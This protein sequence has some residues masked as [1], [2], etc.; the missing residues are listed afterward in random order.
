MCTCR[1]NIHKLCTYIKIVKKIRSVCVCLCVF[2]GGG[3]CRISR[4]IK[5]RVPILFYLYIITTATRAASDKSFSK[6]TCRLCASRSI[7]HFRVL[8]SS[9]LGARAGSIAGMR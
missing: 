1:K 5:V 4:G 3:D 8:F 2:G 7:F 6:T 9:S